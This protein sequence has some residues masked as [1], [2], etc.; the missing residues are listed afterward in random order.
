MNNILE[1]ADCYAFIVCHTI[2]H[3]AESSLYLLFTATY[4]DSFYS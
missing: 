2:K 4:L 1:T 3:S